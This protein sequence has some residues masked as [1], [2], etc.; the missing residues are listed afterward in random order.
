MEK[1]ISEISKLINSKIDS[2]SLNKHTYV[3]TENMFPNFGGVGECTNIPNSNVTSFQTNDILISNIRPYFK[4]IWFARFNGGCSN[5][6]LVIRV[7]KSVDPKYLFYALNDV[8]FIKYY[9]A[10]C[11]GTKM[12]RGNKDALLE[13]KIDV[14]NLDEQQH[15]VN[16][17]S[18]PLLKSL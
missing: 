10:S 6:V 1:K 12:P 5:D 8:N 14:P 16:T 17:I 11:K 15:I 7:N 13:W 2:S 4:K 3:S 18:I 9:V